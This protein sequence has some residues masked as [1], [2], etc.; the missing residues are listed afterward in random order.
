MHS[1]ESLERLCREAQQ[2]MKEK[3]ALR[4][5]LRIIKGNQGDSGRS[6]SKGEG[7]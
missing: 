7:E 2:R 6:S 3:E 4:K 5:K 1:K